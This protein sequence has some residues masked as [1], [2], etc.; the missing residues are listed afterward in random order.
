ME[1][2][3]EDE[4]PSLNLAPFLFY[5]SNLGCCPGVKTKALGTQVPDSPT[6]VHTHPAFWSQGV[7]G[8]KGGQLENKQLVRELNDWS[9][10][11]L[12]EGTGMVGEEEEE[13][14]GGREW[15]RGGVLSPVTCSGGR[16]GGGETSI[17]LPAPVL[18]HLT[19][20]ACLD[21]VCPLPTRFTTTMTPG[22]QAPFFFLLLLVPVHTG[23]GHKVGK[24]LPCKAFRWVLFPGR[25]YS[26]RQKWQTGGLVC[27]RIK[28]TG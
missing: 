19:S 15:R 12:P 24:G 2:G 27:A 20:S 16:G 10:C 6:L 7:V 4:L 21:L 9:P 26:T 1:S 11:A 13:E 8:E 14:R 18:L 28:E 5:L 22:I 23:E 17:K 3:T 25:C